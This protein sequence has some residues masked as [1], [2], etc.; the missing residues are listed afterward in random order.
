MRRDT[1]TR[2]GFQLM[3]VLVAIAIAAGPLLLAFHLVQ[4]NAAGARFNHGRAVERLILADLAEIL[5]AQP[6]ASLRT[7]ADHPEMVTTGFTRRLEAMPASVREG[8]SAEVTP[9]LGR[10]A[11]RFEEELDPAAADLCRL[12]L[13]LR[14]DERTGLT[15]RVTRLFRPAARLLPREAPP[16]ERTPS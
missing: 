9:Y 8:Y 14:V 13:E 16:S 4:Q 3:E 5:V 2:A 12:T 11:A 15:V 7:I 6:L 10:I 1:R